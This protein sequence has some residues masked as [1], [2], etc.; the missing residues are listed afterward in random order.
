MKEMLNLRLLNRLDN[1]KVFPTVDGWLVLVIT[2]IFINILRKRKDD[3]LDDGL[4]CS[5]AKLP[6]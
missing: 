6:L 3:I 2:S 5:S 1:C 4:F